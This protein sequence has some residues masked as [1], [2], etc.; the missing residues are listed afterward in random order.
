[1]PKKLYYMN[2]AETLDSMTDCLK[3]TW[4][5]QLAVHALTMVFYIALALIL[6]AP[7][8]ALVSVIS[9][10]AEKGSSSYGSI[11][12]PVAI[13]AAITALMTC[14][15]GSFRMSAIMTLAKQARYNERP[16]A[17]KAFKVAIR[18]MFRVMSVSIVSFIAFLPA[19][20][21]AA[22]PIAFIINTLWTIS[23]AASAPNPLT[24]PLTFLT[25]SRTAYILP[26]VAA[27][28]LFLTVCQLFISAILGIMYPV[29]L[30]EKRWFFGAATRGFKLV[31]TDFKLVLG[32]TAAQLISVSLISQSVQF[33]NAIISFMP[34]ENVL[35]WA[36][37]IISLLFSSLTGIFYACLY[38]NQRVKREGF[39]IELNL[40]FLN[41]AYEQERGS[42]GD[43]VRRG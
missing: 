2:V 40:A 36:T 32:L 15:A 20:A 7:A 42:S 29:S 22:I 26:T 16:S 43:D 3:K 8:I 34:F 17:P 14:A 11:I 6:I 25:D 1:M 27:T 21:I 12:A 4:K 35:S 18:S 5:Q 13:C 37:W 24:A 30:F 38:I 19:L 10:L 39:D 41:Y 31:K 9:A 33:I 23:T 28:V